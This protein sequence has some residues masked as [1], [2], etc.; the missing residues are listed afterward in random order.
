MLAAD[1][2]NRQNIAVESRRTEGPERQQPGEVHTLMLFHPAFHNFEESAG[3]M[4]ERAARWVDKT[5]LAFDLQL[6]HANLA[7]LALIEIVFDAHARKE[8]YAL[9]IF[10]HAANGFHGWHF[11]FHVE[12]HFV[13][14]ELTQD[15][16]AIWRDDVMGDKRL[17]AQIGDRRTL[18]FSKW[19]FG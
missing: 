11:D 18:S 2:E 15:D 6:L 14:L 16:V 17:P 10:H 19:M 9:V 5:N 7:Q 8:S 3:R 13:A 1:L 4:A 12:G